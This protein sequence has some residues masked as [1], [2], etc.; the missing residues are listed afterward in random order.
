MILKRKNV[1]LF[2]P[3]RTYVDPEVKTFVNT[4]KI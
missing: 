1:T 2:C 3:E 4:S